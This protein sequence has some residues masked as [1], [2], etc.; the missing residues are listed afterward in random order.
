MHEQSC[1]CYV[2]LI[3]R[4]LFCPSCCRRCCLSCLHFLF[5]LLWFL[6]T[7]SILGQFQKLFE[8]SLRWR[9]SQ[10]VHSTITFT[11]NRSSLSI[12]QSPPHS[13]TWWSLDKLLCCLLPL[14]CASLWTIY[15]SMLQVNEK[16]NSF[17]KPSSLVKNLSRSVNCY[18]HS[19]A[20]PFATGRNCRK[21][22]Y[23][24]KFYQRAFFQCWTQISP[25]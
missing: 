6:K 13:D 3:K 21:L 20:F 5:S 14:Q 10:D 19:K 9:N 23:S 17:L 25:L 24:G 2:S 15:Q 1:C 16:K 7:T 4:L 22:T 11:H 8:K 18:D 12:F